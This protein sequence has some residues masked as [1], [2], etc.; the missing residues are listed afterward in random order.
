MGEESS[1]RS[2][3]RKA[4]STVPLH[5]FLDLAQSPVVPPR[6]LE[7]QGPVGRNDRSANELENKTGQTISGVSLSNRNYHRPVTPDMFWI[8]NKPPPGTLA[9]LVLVC[10][11]RK[12]RSQRFLPRSCRSLLERAAESP[13]KK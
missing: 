7:P 9:P 12:C 3:I 10:L 1:K 11:R 13:L 5:Y 8:L 4:H 6:Q 2:Y